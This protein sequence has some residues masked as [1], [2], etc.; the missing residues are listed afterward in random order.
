M[1][2]QAKIFNMRQGGKKLAAVRDQ[3]AAA[4]VPGA[5]LKRLDDLADKLLVGT[6]GEPAFKKVPGYKWAT[7]INVNA[8]IVHGIPHAH[9]I[10]QDGDIVSLDVGLWYQGYYTD[11]S[12]TVVAGTASL[13]TQRFLAA[14]KHA[15]KTAIN[16]AK[17][18]LRIGH[19]SRAIQTSIETAG[20]N[21]LRNYTG[22][23]VGKSLHEFPSI[24]CVLDRPLES[25]PIIEPGMTLAIEVMYMMGLPEVV[26]LKD[27][28]TIATKDGSSS[29][30]FEETIIVGKKT[31]EIIT[32]SR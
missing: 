4:I 28:W 12:I 16:L 27:G 14:G 15:L 31:P 32:G 18:G 24:P 25:T 6:G 9:I 20:Y 23:G 10:I 8:G 26:K 13:E 7:C 2:D 5:N 1:I 29:G 3:V 22:H 30:L 17:P 11:T 21:C 19:I